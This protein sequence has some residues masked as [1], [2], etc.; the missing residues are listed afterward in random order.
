MK[1]PLILVF[2]GWAAGPET[3]DLIS[4]PHDW[5][6]S[7]VEQMEGVH[8][9][10][11]ESSEELIL[12]GFSMG[13]VTAQEIVLK[14]PEKIKGLLLVSA[15]PRMMED[16]ATDWKGLSPRRLE[17][18]RWGTEMV[19]KDDPSPMYDKANMDRGLDFLQMHDLRAA[20]KGIGKTDFPVEVFH[21]ER[22]GIVRPHN[23]DFFKAV[24]PQARV[25]MIPGNEHVLPV[26]IPEKLDEAMERI[27]AHG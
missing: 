17:A 24:F 7:Y 23:P 8:N 18:L 22:D 6:F 19:F 5:V 2:N 11:V 16:K 25:T 12:V 3:W 20:L 14:N 13:G 15:T 1:R 4:F 9:A 27:L 10:I 26:T 21:S